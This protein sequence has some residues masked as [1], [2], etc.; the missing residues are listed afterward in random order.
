[1]VLEKAGS[2]KREKLGRLI[3]ADDS[4]SCCVDLRLFNRTYCHW[5]HQPTRRC[6]HWHT[7]R[8]YSVLVH[9]IP[10]ASPPESVSETE[11]LL[12]DFIV[13]FRIGG[14]FIYR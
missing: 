9:D 10:A 11:K 1:M 13:L 8:V 3:G 5:F 4:V 7:N 2:Y 12:V 14:E 6:R